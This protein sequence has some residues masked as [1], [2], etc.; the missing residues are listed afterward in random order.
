M[1]VEESDID[2]HLSRLANHYSMEKQ[3]VR[4]EIESKQGMES[5]ER[6]VRAEKTLDFLMERA[7]VKIK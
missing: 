4:A 3:Q 5:L 2:T 6:N 7:K 1:I